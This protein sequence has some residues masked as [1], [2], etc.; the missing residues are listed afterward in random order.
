MFLTNLQKGL[1]KNDWKKTMSFRADKNVGCKI[2]K[3]GMKITE[4]KVLISLGESYFT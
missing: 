4:N 3:N 1:P 2:R